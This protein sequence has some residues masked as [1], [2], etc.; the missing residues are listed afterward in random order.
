MELGAIKKVYAKPFIQM[1]GAW[2]AK[3]LQRETLMT[4]EV[5]LAVEAESDKFYRNAQLRN[6]DTI[7]VGSYYLVS[8]QVFNATES[9]GCIVF[10]SVLKPSNLTL[11]Q[12]VHHHWTSLRG[13]ERKKRVFQLLCE[14]VGL[15]RILEDLSSWC[16]PISLQQV[17]MIRIFQSLSLELCRKRFGANSLAQFL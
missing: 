9:S 4:S 2:F 7:Q 13:C 16:S 6:K 10:L 5:T 15:S 3:K 11:P 8:K 14:F 12:Q 17:W 1:D